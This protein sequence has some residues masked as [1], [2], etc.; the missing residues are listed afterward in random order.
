[1]PDTPEV[2]WAQ[3]VLVDQDGHRHGGAFR[4]DPAAAMLVEALQAAG[5]QWRAADPVPDVLL[6]PDSLIRLREELK[7]VVLRT[8]AEVRDDLAPDAYD[9]VPVEVLDHLVPLR[10]RDAQQHALKQLSSLLGSVGDLVARGR[11]LWI[12][13]LPYLDDADYWILSIVTRGVTRAE[14]R[15]ALSRRLAESAAGSTEQ[16]DDP[17]PGEPEDRV[18]WRVDRL[19]NWGLITDDSNRILATHKARQLRF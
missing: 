5:S 11:S 4:T 13:A 9:A 10:V 18:E 16:P 14:L 12:Y 19:R 3:L 8:L 7:T 17:L 1:M 15:E 2:T 6:G